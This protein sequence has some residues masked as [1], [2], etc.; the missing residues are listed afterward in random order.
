MT[1]IPSARAPYQLL[2]LF[3]IL[4]TAIAGLAYRFQLAQEQAIQHEVHNQLLSIAD[5]KVKQITAWRAE[6]LGEARVVLNS[7]FTLAAVQRLVSKRGRGAERVAL[8]NW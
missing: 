2:I 6:K 4:A 5:M 1:P 7:S 8:E 3:V